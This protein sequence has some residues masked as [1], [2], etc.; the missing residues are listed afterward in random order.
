MRVNLIVLSAVAAI[1]FAASPLPSASARNMTT[2]EAGTLLR[3]PDFSS[4]FTTPD[5][6]TARPIKAVR[7]GVQFEVRAANG[8]SGTII[9]VGPAPV[10][11]ERDVV[12]TLI[13]IGIKLW[14]KLQTN[15]GGGGG[16]GKCTSTVT[17][18]TTGGS[19]TTTVTTTCTSS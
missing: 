8:R 6:A 16:G 13:D 17:V 18:T 2:R 7:G 15:G 5:R 3:N 1:A 4:G 14:D 12:G 9:V 10:V 19:S 11:A